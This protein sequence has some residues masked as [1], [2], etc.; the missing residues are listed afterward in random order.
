MLSESIQA[1]ILARE[2]ILIHHKNIYYARVLHRGAIYKVILSFALIILKHVY[3][4][5][6]ETLL[7]IIIFKSE[8]IWKRISIFKHIK[9]L[10]KHNQFKVG[11]QNI[12][13][14]VMVEINV[15][16]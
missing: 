13:L 4:F 5:F 3:N 15:L 8:I 11:I 1:I 2:V 10:K 12:I 9:Q 14:D 16:I 7:N 6:N